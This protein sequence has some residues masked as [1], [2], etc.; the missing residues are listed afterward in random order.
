MATE[1]EKERE[2]ERE[3]ARERE[4]ERERERALMVACVYVKGWCNNV[5]WN[6]G[7]LTWLQYRVAVERHDFY[8]ERRFHSIIPMIQLSWNLAR[9]CRPTMMSCDGRLATVLRAF[10]GRSLDACDASLQCATRLGKEV[11]WHGRV[12]GEPAHYCENCEVPYAAVGFCFAHILL[13]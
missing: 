9:S 10:L 4:R 2:R 5:A 6:V 12:D 13:H 1:T 8:A 3:R 7:P 11:K